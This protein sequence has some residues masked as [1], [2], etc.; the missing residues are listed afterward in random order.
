VKRLSELI[1]ISKENHVK[2]D[3]ESNKS[4]L[5]QFDERVIDQEMATLYRS[6][7]KFGKK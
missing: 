4:F 1:K 3:L 6:E 5:L 2:P 7:S